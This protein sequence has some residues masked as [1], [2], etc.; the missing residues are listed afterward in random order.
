MHLCVKIIKHVFN[1]NIGT[2]TDCIQFSPTGSILMIILEKLFINL[3]FWVQHG[4]NK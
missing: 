2:S 3:N 4:N 1:N